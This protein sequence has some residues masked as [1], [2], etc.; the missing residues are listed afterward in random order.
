MGG[1]SVIKHFLFISLMISNLTATAAPETTPKTGAEQDYSE[2]AAPQIKLYWPED[3]ANLA[4]KKKWSDSQRKLAQELNFSESNLS[5]DFKVKLRE[6]WLKVKTADQLEELLKTSYANYDSYSDDVKFFLN[7]MHP[8]LPLRGIIW[9][10]RPLF[11]KKDEFLGNKSTHVT[12]VQFVRSVATGL[13]M[14]FPTE[15]WEA[16][17]EYITTPSKDMT[18]SMQFKNIYQLQ[19]F[20]MNSYAK[21]VSESTNRTKALLEK[22]PNEI[23]VWDNKMAFGIGAFED[24]IQRYVGYGPAEVNFS[25][26]SGYRT[27]HDINLFC[28]Y[29]QDHIINVAGDFGAHFGMDSLPSFVR[30]KSELGITDKERITVMLNA[31]NNHRF[32]ELRNYQGTT[33]GTNRMRDAYNALVNSVT[34]A[35]NSYELLQGKT[36]TKAMAFNP[37]LYQSQSQDR[38]LTG[39]KNMAAAVKGPTLVRDPISGKSVKIDLPAFYKTPFTSLKSLMPTKFDEAGSLETEIKNSKNEVMKYRNY[40]RGRAVGWNNN[41]EAWGKIVPSAIGQPSHYMSEARRV[42]HFSLGTSIVMITPDIFVH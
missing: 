42:M 27:L 12:A 8:M 15:Q 34:Y 26:A 29:N 4:L 25:I 17:F 28:A 1:E 6:P 38:L 18:L 10:L 21:Q 22:N 31:V 33:Y 37:V 20:L 23:Y 13:K 36:A 35:Q 24:D 7:H 2:G 41:K 11:E 32:L 3:E 14:F 5:Q 40:Y 19:N 30:G 39:V 16:G 9:R